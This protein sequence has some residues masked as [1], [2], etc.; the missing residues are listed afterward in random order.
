MEDVINNIKFMR[1]AIELAKEKEFVVIFL[2]LA[3]RDGLV[4]PHEWSQ[5]DHFVNTEW[6]CNGL[7]E[8]FKT[9]N[10]NCPGLVEFKKQ[11]GLIGLIK[12]PAIRLSEMGLKMAEMLRNKKELKE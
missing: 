6:N 3:S 1:T 9:L 7:V 5:E 10:K 4:D 12:F 2:D 11:K 8:L